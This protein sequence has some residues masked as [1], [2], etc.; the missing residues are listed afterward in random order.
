[1]KLPITALAVSLLAATLILPAG[2]AKPPDLFDVCVDGTLDDG[3][4]GNAWICVGF[5]EQIPFCVDIIR[6]E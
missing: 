3:C 6:L 5:S 1:M 4:Y 2:A